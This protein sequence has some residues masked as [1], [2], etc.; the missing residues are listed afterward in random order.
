MKNKVSPFIKIGTILL[1]VFNL[2]NLVVTL[3]LLS[4]LLATEEGGYLGLMGWVDYIGNSVFSFFALCFLIVAMIRLFK[5][6]NV[7]SG[8]L[9]TILGFVFTSLQSV[10]VG[11]F[12]IFFLIEDEGFNVLGFIFALVRFAALMFL[13]LSTNVNRFGAKSAV[14]Y[15]GIIGAAIIAGLALYGVVT[16]KTLTLNFMIP[17]IATLFFIAAHIFLILF[18]ISLKEEDLTGGVPA[19][20]FDNPNNSMDSVSSSEEKKEKEP[21]EP[22][23]EAPKQEEKEE[24][25]PFNIF[26]D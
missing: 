20:N 10:S 2:Y 8:L 15:L 25:H 26:G 16:S 22:A 6:H 18:Y 19:N 3:V 7:P 5:D 21:E 24:E 12:Q 17:L 11:M 13:A 14:K 9:F 1:T 4:A 23:Q